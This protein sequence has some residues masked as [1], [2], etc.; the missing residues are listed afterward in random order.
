[1]FP[2]SDAEVV[3]SDISS[4]IAR[5]FY[6]VDSGFEVMPSQKVVVTAED[7]LFDDLE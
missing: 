6:A 3:T 7:D 2:I 1:M 5:N 4:S